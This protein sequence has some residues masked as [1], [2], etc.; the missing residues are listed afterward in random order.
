MLMGVL[1]RPSTSLAQ[2]PENA[3]AAGADRG[4][5]FGPILAPPHILGMGGAY[6]AMGTRVGATQFNPAAVATRFDYENWK[7]SR[8]ETGIYVLGSSGLLG[9]APGDFENDGR[10]AAGEAVGVLK[11]DLAWKRG[12]WGFGASLATRS[13][14]LCVRVTAP[15]CSPFDVLKIWNHIAALA[16][17][18]NFLEGQLVAGLKG[19]VPL[20]QVD[21]GDRG[22]SLGLRSFG[23]MAGAIW[24]PHAFNYR[25]G[26]T[27]Y[28]TFATAKDSDALR[29]AELTVPNGMGAPWQLAV[30]AAYQFGDRSFNPRVP[31]GTKTQPNANASAE[32]ESDQDL[33]RTRSFAQFVVTSELVLLGA[34]AQGTEVGLLSGDITQ[35][36]PFAGILRLSPRAGLETGEWDG[37]ARFRLGSYWEPSVYQKEPGRLHGTFGAD[38][39]LLKWL[40]VI[41]MATASADLT[42][43]YRALGLSVGP[44]L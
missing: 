41:W 27:Y 42:K 1:A 37:R 28:R 24:A 34:P 9:F 20:S 21:A 17:G 12:R 43:G 13:Y 8:M 10:S 2:A 35:R 6:T 36:P 38:V 39:R 4:I 44:W 23:L 18:R 40:G 14:D 22:L 3:G 29:L 19:W 32:P 11:V 30:G 31:F 33:R 16:V 26:A 25:L 5:S 15:D 7:Y